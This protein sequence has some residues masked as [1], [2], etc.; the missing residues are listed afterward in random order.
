MLATDFL[1]AAERLPFGRLKD[2]ADDAGLLILAPHPDDESLGCG[3]LIA[4]ASLHRVATQVVM[5]SDG[6]GSHPNSRHWPP[7]RLRALREAETLAALEVLGLPGESAS[8]LRLPDTRV[9][10]EG[11]AFEEAVGSILAGP[12]RAVP[13]GAVLTSW[14]HDPH[15][16]HQATHAIA[17][18]VARRLG[19][20]LY[21]YVV[22]GWAY[23][24]DVPGFVLGPAPPV[25]APPRGLRLDIA[26]HLDAKR[27]AVAAHLS[28]T[29]ALIDDDPQG[30]RLRPEALA[31]MLR[32][33]EVYLEETP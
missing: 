33:F 4:E 26:C 28:Q 25:P 23:L 20:R 9:P 18:A 22:W 3:G 31:F 32:P 30:F 5:V 6:A 21:S 13:V 19:A 2:I 29:T 1:R 8:F 27:R 16:D 7:A 14:G 24:H 12:A 17:A 11:P 10:A 15:G